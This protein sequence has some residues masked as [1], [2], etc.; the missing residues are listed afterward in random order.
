MS[1]K[2][3]ILIIVLGIGF[4]GTCYYYLDVSITETKNKI[5]VREAKNNPDIQAYTKE[6]VMN[7]KLSENK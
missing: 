5:A 4:I 3:L 2:K 6:D 1:L 7:K